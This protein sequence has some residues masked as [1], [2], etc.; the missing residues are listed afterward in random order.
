MKNTALRVILI[1]AAKIPVIY[2]IAAMPGMAARLEGNVKE[3]C[4]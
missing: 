1:I 3:Y 2:P 4:K